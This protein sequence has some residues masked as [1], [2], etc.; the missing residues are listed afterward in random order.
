MP[1][2]TCT[3]SLDGDALGSGNAK[4]MAP[5][6]VAGSASRTLAELVAAERGGELAP[7]SLERFPD[8]EF[9]PNVGDLRGE[10]VYV[11][12]STGPPVSENLTELLLLLDACRR[13]G[14]RRITAVV[15]YFGYARQDRRSRAGEAIGARMATEVIAA[16]GADRLV[17]I[18][19]HTPDLEAMCPIPVE[20]LTAVPAVAH[21]LG[22]LAGAAQVVVAPDRGAIKL[23]E[24]F[25]ALL[26]LPIA[27]VRK[28]R[29]S[30]A[31]VRDEE[32]IGE[33]ARRNRLIVDDM[34][35][36]G[37][38]I[39]AT[40]GLLLES[41]AEPHPVVA[42]SMGSLSARPR[43]ASIGYSRGLAYDRHRRPWARIRPSP[44]LGGTPHRRCHRSLAPGSVAR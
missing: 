42:T 33:V 27:I 44:L 17:V 21:A 23:A 9:C 39:E 26:G 18:D 5:Q 11:I 15:P 22:L 30:G 31:V 20:M 34:I 13:T 25:A 7:S 32:L 41:H 35:S 24:R 14:A 29:T 37:A 36:T 40:A 43:S 2:E 4:T 12:Q 8:G 16:A 3:V 10:D 38:T 6:I 1:R 28:V 19:P